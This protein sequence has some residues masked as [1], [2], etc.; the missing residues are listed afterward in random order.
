MAKTEY[1]FQVEVKL[2][3]QYDSDIQKSQHLGC[4]YRLGASQNTDIGHYHDEEGLP[5]K[6]GTD[7][8][9]KTLVSGLA[10]A[11]H[12]GHQKGYK[13]S[14]VAL[15]EIIKMLEDQFVIPT[16]IDKGKM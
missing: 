7:V 11:I 1:F 13:D 5:N 16:N 12:A 14:A 2:Q 9:V 15:R 4:S 3:L 8:V 6:D 10:A